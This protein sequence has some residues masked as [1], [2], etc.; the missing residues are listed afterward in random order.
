MAARPLCRAICAGAKK[1]AAVAPAVV[2]LQRLPRY[3]FALPWFCYK[4]GLSIRAVL[5]RRPFV[6]RSFL[7]CRP[8][9]LR[10]FDRRFAAARKM[11]CF[12]ARANFKS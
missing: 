12:A 3:S 5:L 2:A 6:S 9:T 4:R 11:S 1:G 10:A 8:L 7:L